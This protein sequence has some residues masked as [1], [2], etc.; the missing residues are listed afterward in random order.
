MLLASFWLVIVLCNNLSLSKWCLHMTVL[1]HNIPDSWWWVNEFSTYFTEVPVT[2]HEKWKKINGFNC[3][4][5]CLCRQMQHQAQDLLWI[6][7][8]SWQTTCQLF[9]TSVSIWFCFVCSKNTSR[10]NEW[11]KL[12]FNLGSQVN[13]TDGISIDDLLGTVDRT[14]YYRYNGSLTT[15]SC[16]EVVVWTVF[17]E[18]VK[19]DQ[20]LVCG[21]TYKTA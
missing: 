7:G 17:K 2:K 13:V 16:N 3:S 19:V 11:F 21:K 10:H 9:R 8:I 6:A 18:S 4:N 12:F 14:A 20:N 5:L 1:P 15:P